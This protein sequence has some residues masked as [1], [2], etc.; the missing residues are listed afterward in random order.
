LRT[1]T[2]I[3]LGCICIGLNSLSQT[4]KN[5]TNTPDLFAEDSADLRDRFTSIKDLLESQLELNTNSE[6]SLDQ[7]V[8]V[9]KVLTGTSSAINSMHK[10]GSVIFSG[11]AVD[12]L[13]ELKDYLLADFN[14]YKNLIHVYITKDPSH[15]AFSIVNGNIYVNVGLLANLQNEAQLAFILSHEIMHIVNKHSIGRQ[16]SEDG[17][18]SSYDD[19]D[20][21][22]D[23]DL[24]F[25]EKHSSEKLDEFEADLD[26]I[27]LYSKTA[28]SY[29]EALQAIESLNFYEDINKDV[30]LT[31]DLLFLPQSELDYLNALK[32]VEIP[33][34][35]A[36]EGTHPSSELRYTALK[37]LISYDTLTHGNKHFLIRDSLFFTELRTQAKQERLN[38]YIRFGEFFKTFIYASNNYQLGDRNKTTIQAIC[39]SLQYFYLVK[40]KKMPIDNFEINNDS[41]SIFS[42]Y[43]VS[44]TLPEFETYYLKV[45]NQL[46]IENPESNQVIQP[47]LTSQ[48]KASAF[49]SNELEIDNIQ[50][51]I[52]ITNGSDMSSKDQRQ[53]PIIKKSETLNPGKI[54]AANI[55]NISIVKKENE[56][57]PLYSEKLDIQISN[58]LSS[59]AENRSSNLI[60]LLPHETS[61]SSSTYSDY[62]VLNDWLLERFQFQT[63]NYVSYYQSE[64]NELQKRT[65]LKYLMAGENIEIQAINGKLAVKAFLSS[66]PV[67]IYIPQNV[68]KM[69]IHRK[70]K[71]M[72]TVFFDLN[73]KQLVAWDRR[74]YLEPN[75]EAQLI[76]NYNNIIYE[77]FKK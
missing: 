33:E 46:L 63:S 14:D 75:T 72:L 65:D 19:K 58:A 54:G 62:Q 34:E 70:R 11:K 66:I 27:K 9:A 67:P 17:F 48:P 12:Y 68:T 71:Y 39:Y 41:E 55:F 18:K 8:S 56:S 23:L 15:N 51:L 10:S 4:Q 61:Y 45:L 32:T 60:N 5:N 53:Y 35:A 44:S 26:G 16:L 40:V 29:N 30:S 1:T 37:E 13:N 73:S 3:L 69:F 47:Y 2:L 43:V 76:Q 25:L 57:N 77:I 28:Y 49:T 36:S 50:F 20:I 59:I 74:T 21:L 38:E 52:N 64:I 24:D 22:K 7:Q 42:K 31:A 6:S